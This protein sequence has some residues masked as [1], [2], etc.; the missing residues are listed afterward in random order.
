MD[1]ISETE[2]S[3]LLKNSSQ[4]SSGPLLVHTVSL[5]NSNARLG[6]LSAIDNHK[7]AQWQGVVSA[8][9]FCKRKDQ[10]KMTQQRKLRNSVA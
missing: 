1:H 5:P 10:G 2:F 9:P 8:K 4:Q 7:I 3:S 6:P